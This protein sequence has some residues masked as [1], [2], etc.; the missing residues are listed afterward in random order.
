[1]NTCSWLI[2]QQHTVIYLHCT[3]SCP[4]PSVPGK[5]LE[6]LVAVGLT[7]AWDRRDSAYCRLPL[8]PDLVDSIHL[9]LLVVLGGM[10]VFLQG[11]MPQNGRRG[12]QRYS[13]LRGPRRESVAL[14][15]LAA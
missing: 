15:P 12:R 2:I 14:M 6:F 11:R 9:G 7:W 8:L 1:M 3:V 13:V 5:S 10:D 4:F